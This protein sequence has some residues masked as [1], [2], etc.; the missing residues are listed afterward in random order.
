MALDC[1]YKH[2][3]QHDG[4]NQLQRFQEALEPGNVPL[5]EFDLR[6]WMRFA[7][8]YA[9]HVKYFSITDANNPHGDWQD[10]MKSGDEIEAWLKDAALVEDEGWISRDERER[11]MKREPQGDY[12]PHLA[13]FLSFLKLMKFPKGQLNGFTKRHLDFYYTRVLQLGRQPALADR[14]HILFELAKNAALET[15]PSG[16]LLDGGKDGNGKPLRYATEQELTVNTATVALMKSIYHKEGDTVRFAEMTNSSDGLGTEF[17]EENPC[18]NAFGNEEWPSATLGFALASS[19]LLMKEGTREVAVSLSLGF[20]DDSDL[21]SLK[22]YQAQL[23][24]FLTGEK[25]W[26]AASLLKVT[27]VP[28]AAVDKL[29]FTVTV[30]SSQK[31]VVPYDPKIHL[32]RLNTNLP[33]L[34]VLVNTDNPDGYMV[35][36]S[37]SRA[38]ITEASITVKVTGA[39]DLAVENDQGRLDPSK[40]FY[41][42]GPLPGKNSNFYVGSSEIFQKTWDYI[43]LNISWKDKPKS[44]YDLYESYL[45]GNFEGT[46]IVGSE[47]YF[48]VRPEYLRD[49]I[50]HP[51]SAEG[52]T[53]DLF[54]TSPLEIKRD[55]ADSADRV[56][57][58]VPP[59]LMKKGIDVNKALLQN[60]LKPPGQEEGAS[61]AKKQVAISARFE[62]ARFDPGFTALETTTERFN[63][64]TKSGYIRLKLM[65]SFLHERYAPLLTLTMIEKSKSDSKHANAALPNEPYTPVI[66]SITADY[67]ATAWNSFVFDKSVTPKQKYDNFTARTIQLFHEHP[68]G[69]AEQHLFLKEQCDFIDPTESRS[70]SPVPVYSPEGEF[71]IGLK[72]APPSGLLSLLFEAVEGSENP[73]AATFGRDQEIEWCALSNNEWKPLN[74]DYV[75]ADDTNNLLRP[76]IVK[77]ILPASINSSNTLLDSGFSWLKA[78]LPQGLE[79][80]SVCRLAGVMAQAVVAV[81]SDNGNELS[82]LSTALPAGS[83]GKLIDKPALIKKVTQL[84]ASYGGA[85]IED[86]HAFYQRVSER[87]R[88]K[89]RGVNIWDYEHLVLQQFPSIHK[90]KCLSHTS[91]RKE[92]GSPDYFELAP[93]YVSLVVIPDIR[94]KNIFDPL[95]PRASQNL[96]GEIEDFI[97]PLNSLHVKFDAANPDYETVLLDF[98]VKFHDDYDANAYR[99]VLNDDIVRYLSP[100]AFGEFSDIHFGG[101]LFK[102]ILIRFI[103]ERAYVDFISHFKMFHRIGQGDVNVI[104]RNEIVAGSARAI[105]V[106]APLHT[107]ELIEKDKVCNE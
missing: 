29:E 5:H 47:Q 53:L 104:D 65:Q 105:L 59:L 97:R 45:T 86:D 62:S 3:L 38:V 98:R 106:S 11:I 101:K 10:F 64:A 36:A 26:M 4:T 13:L 95:Q 18:W 15:V 44:F 20:P 28:L 39:K 1:K 68:F 60:Y 77:V 82:H 58:A 69:Q 102:S 55:G 70:F 43:D 74:K 7:W 84:F 22:Q 2:P 91:T 31:G 63:P 40:P 21:P 50:W 66:A 89:Q 34:R 30:D 37:L 57:P 56:S 75:T 41:P 73:L 72:D 78:S 83:I 25:E 17:K 42:F 54:S 87:L 71:Y 99:K 94:N 100:W 52:K 9:G 8:Y 46:R 103:E 88:H 92:D 35:Y 85:T 23:N 48:Q 67:Q 19:V 76:G 12:Q 79:H 6:D 81:F 27:R 16:A 96:L 14:V 32:E 90:V 80:T 93:G 49:N 61:A 33:V 24:V 51:A 107:I